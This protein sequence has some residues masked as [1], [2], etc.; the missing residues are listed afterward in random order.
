MWMFILVLAFC[1]VAVLLLLIF[2]AGPAV[3]VRNGARG[4]T[5]I[6]GVTGD[7]G[8]SGLDGGINTGPSGEL[9]ATGLPGPTGITGA[10]SQVTGN[11]GHRGLTGP[12][13][14]P[15]TGA[16]TGHTGPTGIEGLT[17]LVGIN[18]GMVNTGHTGATGIHGVTG[19][20]GA[21]ETGPA[22]AHGLTGATGVV[23]P[24]GSLT[25][26]G[27]TG[28]LST[29]PLHTVQVREGTGPTA[30]GASATTTIAYPTLVFNEGTI[31][32]NGASTQFT[33]PIEGMYEITAS[34][35]INTLGAM[36]GGISDAVVQ[37]LNNTNS[38]T[39]ARQSHQVTDFT[40]TPGGLFPPAGVAALT[41]STQE[42][43]QAGM[44]FSILLFTPFTYTIQAGGSLTVV[45]VQGENPPPMA[46]ENNATGTQTF[47]IYG[48]AAQQTLIVDGGVVTG[49]IT[50][51]Y[52]SE[53]PGIEVKTGGT[54]DVE[55]RFVAPVDGTYCVNS[56][57]EVFVQTENPPGEQMVM[58][59]EQ[60]PTG[61]DAFA[62]ARQ[63][64]NTHINDSVR[65]TLNG[66]SHM[67]AGTVVDVRSAWYWQGAINPSLPQF[68]PAASDFS[69]VLVSAAP[70]PSQTRISTSNLLLPTNGGANI[71]FP[72][73]LY[74]ANNEFAAPVSDVWTF[75]EQGVYMIQVDVSVNFSAPFPSAS[76]SGETI[77]LY[78]EQLTP[79][80][81]IVQARQFGYGVITT[82]IHG[83]QY[84]PQINFTAIGVF[85]AGATGRLV[86]ANNASGGNQPIPTFIAHTANRPFR[87]TISLIESTSSS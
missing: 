59:V 41:I 45:L 2:Y 53:I 77:F 16:H 43:L 7:T 22:G 87:C 30:V 40:S 82:A 36:G 75:P 21:R 86:Y 15:G 18:A 83:Q 79:V 61:M 71:S 58:F 48:P 37:V 85:A 52:R 74:S 8:P 9:G 6:R 57:M 63:P 10:A 64:T 46:L 70:K 3:N 26:T 23:G 35:W 65:Y 1:I 31:S 13:G 33:V 20:T 56:L 68:V 11:T 49:F 73:L 62:I 32:A 28:P 50:E 84:F 72:T 27:S 24:A 17:G 47:P 81:R 80:N 19:P 69:M 4:A 60:T 34:I 66:L 38:Q 39:F 14:F 78:F 51:D 55:L 5:G 76:G 44:S 29:G 12:Q 25:N 54:G 42:Y 67:R